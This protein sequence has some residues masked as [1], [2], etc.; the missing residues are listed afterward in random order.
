MSTFFPPQVDDEASVRPRWRLL[1]RLV[2]VLVVLV[3]LALVAVSVYAA[4]LSHTFTQHVV[5]QPL[6]PDS[7][8]LGQPSAGATAAAPTGSPRPPA[9]KTDAVNYVLMGSD[10][11]IAADA[12]AG[13]SDSLMV[14]H[15]AADR[16]HAYLISFPR[17][18][19]VAIPGRGKSKINAAFS[20]GGPQLAVRTL[21]ALLDTRMEH[22]ALI[23]FDGFTRLTDEL[24]GVTVYNK[25]ESTSRGYH[26]PSGEITVRGDQALAY[27][28][29]R[30]ELPRGDL[31]RAER[32]RDVVKAIL[33]KGLSPETVA[34]PVKFNGFV[35]GVAEH[36]VVD[37]ELS[38]SAIR[39]TALSLRMTGSD[40]RQLQAPISGFA[41]IRGQSVDVVNH[42]QL[43]ELSRALQEDTVEDYLDR[44]PGR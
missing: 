30:Y 22:A 34:N 26:F 31:D 29:E 33:D 14:L 40:V 27:V 10:S 37:S 23:D 16:K 1:R 20:W 35:A 3:V 15:L 2:A 6:L 25:H 7:G 11:R 28:R 19:Y 13:R 24:G 5:R 39:S 4:L 41:T 38:D 9:G 21:E 36:V 43:R 44:H 17:D 42:G 18:M 12:G 32:Q 8:G